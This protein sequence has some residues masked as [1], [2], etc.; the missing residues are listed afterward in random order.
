M[1][2]AFVGLDPLISDAGRSVGYVDDSATDETVPYEQFLHHLVVGMGIYAEMRVLVV[3][4]V[5]TGLSYSFVTAVGSNTV[6]N[7]IRI[8]VGP[9]SVFYVRIG[10]VGTGNK[11]ES[12]YY[13]PRFVLTDMAM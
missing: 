11:T 10:R 12:T 13:L 5:D 9:G 1:S 8:I 7:V 3:T 2:I 6:D 4:P